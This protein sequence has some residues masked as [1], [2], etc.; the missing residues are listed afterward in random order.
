MSAGRRDVSWGLNLNPGR[1]EAEVYLVT[2]RD[3]APVE[4]DLLV[5]A[6]GLLGFEAQAGPAAGDAV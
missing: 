1:G 2:R 6:L 4:A 3:L 5:E